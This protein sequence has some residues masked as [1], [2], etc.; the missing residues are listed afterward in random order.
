[1]T[2]KQI[3]KTLWDFIMSMAQG[4]GVVWNWLN[5]PIS[6][7][8]KLDLIGVDWSITFTPMMLTGGVL[9]TILILGFIKAFIPVA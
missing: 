1:M 2:G 5:R 7:G 4:M 6:L 9:I 3:I 8:L